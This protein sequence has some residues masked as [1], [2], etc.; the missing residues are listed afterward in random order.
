MDCRGINHHDGFIDSEVFGRRDPVCDLFF[1]RNAAPKSSVDPAL[2]TRLSLPPALFLQK[3]T[4]FG[5]LCV[6]LLSF[7]L[8]SDKP[9]GPTVLKR[10]HLEA[11]GWTVV[12][13]PHMQVS[14]PF[15]RVSYHVVYGILGYI[16]NH[17]FLGSSISFPLFFFFFF[18]LGPFLFVLF[19]E[20]FISSSSCV[21]IYGFCF[22][23][24]R[25][26]LFFGL[27]EMQWETLHTTFERKQYMSRVLK[28][29]LT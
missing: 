26:T 27:I 25:L 18:F 13:V 17:T 11:A 9:M 10:R 22:Y 23:I 3:K 29:Y 28:P 5:E 4:F 6:N 7:F 21:L 19:S 12:S 16:L 20:L 24:H 1:S 14:D 2:V 8:K 15:A